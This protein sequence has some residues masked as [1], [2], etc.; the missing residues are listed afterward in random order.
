M[1]Q[2]EKEKHAVAH[3]TSDDDFQKFLKDNAGKYVWGLNVCSEFLHVECVR[4]EI[5]V[6]G[7]CCFRCLGIY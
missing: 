1:A 2:A 5:V 3:C 7:V 6:C 4:I